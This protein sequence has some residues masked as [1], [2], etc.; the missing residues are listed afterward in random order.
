MG[1]ELTRK[2]ILRSVGQISQIASARSCQLLT[3]RAGGCKTIEVT[4]GG[5]L[6]FTALQDRCLDLVDFRYKGVN[7]SFLAKPGITAPQ[8]FDPHDQFRYYFQA[9]FLY[10]C[11]LRNVGTG[12]TD[13]GEQ[14]PLHGRIGSISA[15]NIGVSTRWEGDEYHLDIFGDMRES[16][17]F[18]ENLLLSRRIET[19]LGA[20]SL[21]IIDR[22]ANETCN[23]ENMM[24]LYHINFGFP[25]L[26]PELR[27]LLPEGTLTQPRDEDAVK[28]IDAF[29]RFEEPVDEYREQCFYHKPAAAGDG[30]SLALLLNGGLNLAVWIKYNVNQLPCLT[31][32][33]CMASGDY[34]LGIEPANCHVEGRAKERLKGTLQSL[35]PFATREFELEIGVLDGSE[36]DEFL[37]NCTPNLN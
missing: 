28:G 13:G 2:E 29:R 8:Y 35:E 26:G 14:H 11:G 20:N 18:G 16:A 6:S 23:A 32:W 31:Q 9:G 37:R 15:D 3:G 21:R 17:L 22:V 34:A 19:C 25:F 10:T 36:I 5:G 33:K 4:T 12:D 24:L 1:K 30:T 27:L 7:L